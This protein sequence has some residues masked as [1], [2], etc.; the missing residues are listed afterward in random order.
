MIDTLLKGILYMMLSLAL[1][2]V[3]GV[4]AAIVVDG[5]KLG[6]L[7]WVLATA[8]TLYFGGFVVAMLLMVKE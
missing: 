3:L 8:F 7:Q 2:A 4:A 5:A 6:G 1:L